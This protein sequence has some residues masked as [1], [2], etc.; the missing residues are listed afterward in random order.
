MNTYIVSIPGLN[1]EAI[2]CGYD[3]PE[4]AKRAVAAVDEMP[5]DG[6]HERWLVTPVT[7][8]TIIYRD[9]YPEPRNGR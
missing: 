1:W 2:V 8:P 5:L 3:T 7:V 4:A 6:A 9:I